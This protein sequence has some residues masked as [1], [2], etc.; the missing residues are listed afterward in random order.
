ME[1]DLIKIASDGNTVVLVCGWRQVICA[2]V[3]LYAAVGWL[4]W[5]IHR[6]S[7]KRGR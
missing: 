7:R 3:I 4:T 1:Y 6:I 2:L 5:W